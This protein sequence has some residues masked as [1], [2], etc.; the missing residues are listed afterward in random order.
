MVNITPQ[1]LHF[2]DLFARSKFVQIHFLRLVFY[3]VNVVFLAQFIKGQKHSVNQCD[4]LH[5][6]NFGAN[7][8]KAI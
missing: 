7:V 8:I 6:S 4:D 5:R 1:F 2:C 3:L